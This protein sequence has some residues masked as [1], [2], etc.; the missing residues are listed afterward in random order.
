[1]GIEIGVKNGYMA[2]GL[3]NLNSE[4]FFFSFR[5]LSFENPDIELFRFL[6]TV[7]TR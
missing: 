4:V 1:M 7:P 2:F 3:R 6:M 5:N